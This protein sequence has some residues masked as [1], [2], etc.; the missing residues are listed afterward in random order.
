M[1]MA[2]FI[3]PKVAAAQSNKPAGPELTKQPTLYVV[4]YA[5]L[6]TQWRWEYPQVIR[7]YLPS[8]MHLNFDLFEKYPH[9]I[10]NFSGANRYRMMKEYYPADYEKLKRYVAA[11]RWFPAGSS[12]EEGDVN[13]PSPESILRQFLYG[14]EFFR[15]EFGKASAEYMLPDCF[16]FPSSLPSL[17]AHAGI[18]GFSTQKLTWGSSAPVGGPGSP[19]DTPVGTP[20][21]VGIWEGPD[22]K[23]VISALNPGD[24]GSEITY[25]LSKSSPKP[26]GSEY[27]D[28][29]K[30]VQLDGKVSGLF[31]DYHYYGTGDIGGSP[32]EA[33]VKLLEAI[34]TKSLTVLPP[35]RR[36]FGFGEQPQAPEPS[37]PEVRV[38]DG[39]LHVI[40]SVADQMFLDILKT[41]NTA[42]LPRYK[43]DLELT[44]HSAGSLTSEA[45]HKRWNRKNE[46]LADAAERAS[47][48]AAWLGG[49]PY[50]LERL[51][52]AWTLVMGGQ[53]HDIMAG[54]ATP[55]SY[56]YSWN[57]DVLAMN[58]FAGVLTSAVQAI[59]SGLN[60]EASGMPIVVYNPLNIE[61][62]DVVEA[63]VSFPGGAP[64]AVRV[65]GPDG[66]EVPAQ[67][68]EVGAS[69][70]Q[71]TDRPEAERPTPGGRTPF[72]PTKV[73]F[74]AKAPSVGFAVYNV[75]AAKAPA[76]TS[77]LKATESSLENARY[78]L[79][80]D[81]NGDV[82]SLFDKKLNRELLS[83]P[84]RLAF[85]TEKPQ[86]WPAW[87]MDWADQQKPPRAYVQAPAKVRIV[88]N[89]P[90]RV[91]LEVEREA[92]G[93][94]FVEAI[95][96]SAGEAGNRVEFA[97]AIDWRT[98]EAALKATIP[99][100]AS[101]P[102][103]TYNW[104]VGTLQ[105]GNND[106]KK[107]EVASH[108]WFDLT[109][110]GGAYGVTVLSDC[111][112]GSDKPDDSTLRLTLI[113]SPGISEN[114]R[115]YG[116]QATQDWGHHEFVYG[117][118][119]HAGDWRQGETDWQA[120]RLND[121]LIAFE[122][123][124]HAGALGKSFSFLR[125]S[126]SG[127]RVMAVKK[128]E[129]SDEVVVRVVEMRGHAAPEVR[130]SFAA[131][132]AAGRE[133]NGQ[134]QP[135]GKAS[136]AHGEL[137]TSLTPY[138]IR[139]FA[140]KLAA[141]PSKVAA[142]HSQPV[143]LNYNLAA[144]SD[145]GSR[146]VGG[147]D[148]AG[149]ALPAERLPTELAYNGIRFQLAP[150]WAGQPN[151][152]VARGQT[153]SLP[154]GKFN[155]LY[156]L[157]ASADGDQ[158]ATFRIGSEPVELTVQDW[159]GYIG[160]WDNRTWKQ[161]EMPLPPEPAADDTSR[162]AQRARRLRVYVK[163]HGPI[164]VPEYAGLMPGFIKRAPVAW[165][166]SH[167]HSPDGG[168]EPYAYSYLFA[169]SMDVPVDA[170]TLTLPDN[171]KVRILA[172]SVANEAGQ[173][174]P[175]QPLYDTLERVAER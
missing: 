47:V 172:V 100:T 141:A 46:L 118:A 155:R 131:P 85:Q 134:E 119:A 144:A 87:N 128:A 145:E 66:K 9:Y 15:R 104:G 124:K 165:F 157:A 126:Q 163:E 67:L 95:S 90:V 65:I 80:L 59:A 6:D 92:E 121:P 168:N 27:V 77:A 107:F 64:Q 20:F 99:L 37:G 75:Q 34:V 132:V 170:K 17:L 24:Y 40:S 58:Q 146:S 83:A 129:R 127:V 161:V 3:C 171:G 74:L 36:E 147:F 130:I 16:G 173:V 73:L 148:A 169:Y 25:D 42:R 98:K 61:R 39:P 166:A 60:T 96:L 10:F 79:R 21:N 142:P 120:Y 106:E 88:E 50:P 137:Q 110:K 51:N 19:E 133:I 22:G 49:R 125:V 135:Q 86:Q 109:D 71:P 13:S 89:G 32:S 149:Q 103:A 11:G 94:R 164:M 162:R 156:I 117:L 31:A 152:V 12:M 33:S 93:S 101:N 112:T 14:N 138:Q 63:T 114:G 81:A 8:T 153:I 26:I 84:A 48:A 140:V 35:P 29:V 122:S 97:N 150:A 70:R 76:A 30:R 18:K 69:V 136:V 68:E 167:R 154:P 56:E 52:D 143:P 5:H 139:S 113:Y 102:K 72:G 82:A 175:A 151:A 38:G 123:P 2:L 111:K 116:D 53:F 174:R 91:A 44:N 1:A 115:A 28:W 55:K 54:T 23:G 105:R 57:D 108:Q 159:G 43:G 45:V 4:G 41:G 7:E 62:E 78:R 160:Q 158:K